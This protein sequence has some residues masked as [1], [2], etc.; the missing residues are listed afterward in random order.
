MMF[1]RNRVLGLGFESG[2]EPS[3]FAL[4]GFLIE[5][6]SWLQIQMLVLRRLWRHS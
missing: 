3:A 5:F 4:A 6:T 2:L 1:F